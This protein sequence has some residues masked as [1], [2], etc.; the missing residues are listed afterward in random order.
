MENKNLTIRQCINSAMETGN[1]QQ[2]SAYFSEARSRKEIACSCFKELIHQYEDPRQLKGQWLNW[3]I[4]PSKIW[5]SLNFDYTEANLRENAYTSSQMKSW[6][7]DTDKSVLPPRDALIQ[8]AFSL[9]LNSAETDCLLRNAG[10]KSLYMLD[11]V[12]FVSSYYLDYY[13]KNQSVHVSDFQKRKS[14]FE[15]FQGFLIKQ[16]LAGRD[17]FAHAAYGSYNIKY[18]LANESG[19]NEIRNKFYN[20]KE[21][22]TGFLTAKTA[23]PTFRMDLECMKTILKDFQESNNICILD[24]EIKFNKRKG[25]TW[26]FPRII[27]LVTGH[28]CWVIQKKS[29]NSTIQIREKSM[30]Q[31]F[32]TCLYQSPL[33][34]TEPEECSKWIGNTIQNLNKKLGLTFHFSQQK[35]QFNVRR[36]KRDYWIVKIPESMSMPIQLQ[37][38]ACEQVQN[39]VSATSLGENITENLCQYRAL[40]DNFSLIS[41]RSDTEYPTELGRNIFNEIAGEGKLTADRLETYRGFF[42]NRPFA[43]FK[44]NMDFFNDFEAYDKNLRIRSFDSYGWKKLLDDSLSDEEYFTFKEIIEYSSTDASKTVDMKEMIR[45]LRDLSRTT[46]NNKRT[47]RENLQFQILSF[48]G[49]RRSQLYQNYTPHIEKNAS[50]ARNLIQGRTTEKRNRFKSTNDST[51]EMDLKIEDK[52]DFIKW[53]IITGHEDQIGIYLKKLGF[54]EENYIDS[55]NRHDN[56]YLFDRKDLLLIYALQYRDSLLESWFE[57][58]SKREAAKKQFPFIEL[59]MNIGDTVLSAEK[60]DDGSQP[61]GKGPWTL[62]NGRKIYPEDLVFYEPKKKT[63]TI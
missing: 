58:P 55:D 43:F 45:Q 8:C 38:T 22:F 47:R 59:L 7:N 30:D 33:S 44:K 35:T 1:H 28:T 23:E 32:M 6:I 63:E 56:K 40:S 26:D 34:S 49:N 13:Y 15:M 48:I 54:W 41:D 16:H 31:L 42:L 36:E 53:L 62:K 12:D 9:G 14:A 18:T 46:S 61:L 20:V 2:F 57:S 29:E 3:K 19:K 5:R 17:R 25:M 37:V 11:V 51:Y 24:P 21:E 27:L 52:N 50:K 10:Y 39:I 60:R 4:L